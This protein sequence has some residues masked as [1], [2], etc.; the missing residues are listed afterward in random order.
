MSALIGRPVTHLQHNSCSVCSNGLLIAIIYRAKGVTFHSVHICTRTHQSAHK[1]DS[2]LSLHVMWLTF[3]WKVGE[4][5]ERVCVR[6]MRETNN[7]A[8]L[9]P[10]W[11]NGF[12]DGLSTQAELFKRYVCVFALIYMRVPLYILQLLGFSIFRINQARIGRVKCHHVLF[13]WHQEVMLLM[14]AHK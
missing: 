4:W 1:T 13:M 10:V 14:A 2:P 7:T 3:E 5:V 6:E 12:L 8:L 9:G 11:L